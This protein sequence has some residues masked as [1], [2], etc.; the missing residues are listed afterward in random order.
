MSEENV[1]LVRASAD[2]VKGR[3]LRPEE[4]PWE[5]LVQ[6]Q[7]AIALIGADTVYVDNVLPDHAGEEYR[8]RDGVA[9]A[10]ELWI[11]DCEWLRGELLEIIDADA[12][13]VSI[14]KMHMKMR[15]TGLEFESPLAYVHTFREGECVRME[16]FVDVGEALQ[17]A[18]LK[19]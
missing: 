5:Q 2:V 3:T 13:V 11:E 8:G 15:H 9:R 1:R 4:R 14:F 7:A 17:A 12:H 6:H 10:A 19:E 16:S 18:G